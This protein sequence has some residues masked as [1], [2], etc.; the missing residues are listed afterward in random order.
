[1]ASRWIGAVVVNVVVLCGISFGLWLGTIMPF[2]EA[3]RL[4]PQMLAAYVQPY[5]LIIL[6]NVLFTSAIFLS[7]AMLTRKRMPHYIGGAALLLGYMLSQTL[8]S[9]LNTKWIAA[10]TDPFGIGPLRLATISPPATSNSDRE[11]LAF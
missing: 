10:L 7:M 9:D 6:P 5:L 1:M 4:G 11:T 2:V 8:L 3:D